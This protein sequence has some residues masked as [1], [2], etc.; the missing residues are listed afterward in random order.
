MISIIWR[1]ERETRMAWREGRWSVNLAARR[2]V[3]GTQAAYT[4]VGAAL[5]LAPVTLAAGLDSGGPLVGGALAL[6]GYGEVWGRAS[7]VGSKWFWALGGTLIPADYWQVGVA[8]DQVGTQLGLRA[9]L[10]WQG[11]EGRPLRVGGGYRWGEDAGPFAEVEYR[12]G[13]YSGTAEVSRRRFGVR[14]TAVW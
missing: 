8:H 12:V 13:S 7:R 4:G 14:F 2:G 10:P 6:G 3:G 5:N 11:E 1:G 9:A